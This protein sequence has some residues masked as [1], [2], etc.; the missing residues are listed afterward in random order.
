MGGLQD[1]EVEVAIRH[2]QFCLLTTTSCTRKKR[3]G[4]LVITVELIK[5]INQSIKG[6]IGGSLFEVPKSTL[7]SNISEVVVEIPIQVHSNAPPCAVI[8]PVL[9]PESCAGMRKGVTIERDWV[10]F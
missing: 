3:H 8:T 1:L 6:L 4:P 7:T 2:P 10:I 9:A 5:A